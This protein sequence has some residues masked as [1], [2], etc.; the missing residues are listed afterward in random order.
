MKVH[1]APRHNARLRIALDRTS[2][3]SGDCPSRRSR[4]GVLT[5]TRRHI[6]LV[7]LLGVRR[8]VLAVLRGGAWQL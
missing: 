3:G 8:V 5:Q 6:Y 4:K 1:R 2:Y 7:S